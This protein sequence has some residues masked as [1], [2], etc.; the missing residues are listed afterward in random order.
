MSGPY[1]TDAE[2]PPIPTR[3]D[4]LALAE[5]YVCP[6]RVRTFAAL[7]AGIVMGRREGYRIHDVD[8]R[9]W[10]DLHLNGGVFNLG[11]RNPELIAVLVDALDEL[12]IGNHHFPSVEQGAARR[13]PRRAHPRDDLRRVR[14]RRR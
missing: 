12:D 5:R 11:H 4:V 8:G 6:D 2:G 3:D 13:R 1:P 7:G 14:Q 10:L 9:S